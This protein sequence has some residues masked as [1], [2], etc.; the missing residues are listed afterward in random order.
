MDANIILQT[1]DTIYFL[2]DRGLPTD[3]GGVALRLG[4]GASEVL[5]A[6]AHLTRRGLLD[7]SGSRLTMQGLAAAV[8]LAAARRR[9]S[10]RIAA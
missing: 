7:E 9:R 10:E 8:A 2:S 5:D 6:M 1:L 4:V 3:A